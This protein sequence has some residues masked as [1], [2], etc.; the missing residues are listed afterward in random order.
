[1]RK[2][3]R[4][5]D[6]DRIVAVTVKKERIE[7]HVLYPAMGAKVPSDLALT[8]GAACDTNGSLLVDDHLRTSVANMWAAGDVTT[9]LHQISVTT[10]HAAIA[11]TDIHNSLAP[12]CR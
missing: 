9:D 5:A 2:G 10:G 6:G 12:N 11:A 1:L 4:S 7:A 8:V 3:R